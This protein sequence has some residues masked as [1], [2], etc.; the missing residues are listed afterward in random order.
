MLLN[1]L[2]PVSVG[3]TLFRYHTLYRPNWIIGGRNN[4]L[5]FSVLLLV[6]AWQARNLFFLSHRRI[7]ISWSKLNENSDR[8]AA[9]YCLQS[10]Y[11]SVDIL[12][13]D[14]W[15]W[16][17]SKNSRVF[18]FA[19]FLNLRKSRKFHA[20]EI[21]MVYSIRL[22]FY[23]QQHNLGITLVWNWVLNSSEWHQLM[24]MSRMCY[25]MMM[26]W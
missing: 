5:H 9:C 1:N 8:N 19:I 3:I 23:L 22:N 15:W 18:N 7:D 4:W 20:R 14:L 17:I 21:Y 12:C 24:E 10:T 6:G 26:N 13:Q 16:A 11:G 25:I 2:F